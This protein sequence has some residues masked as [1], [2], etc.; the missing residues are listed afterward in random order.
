MHL[1]KQVYEW[2]GTSKGDSGWK[3]IIGEERIL[4]ND[5]RSVS[6]PPIWKWGNN[7]GRSWERNSRRLSRYE[8]PMHRLKVTAFSAHSTWIINASQ[9]IPN[10]WER[11]EPDSFIPPFSTGQLWIKKSVKKEDQRAS[12]LSFLFFFSPRFPFEDKEGGCVLRVGCR[13]TR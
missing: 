3:R 8:W 2:N 9:L 10:H 12:F 6:V 11:A 7:R 1:Y 4:G 13:P 5:E